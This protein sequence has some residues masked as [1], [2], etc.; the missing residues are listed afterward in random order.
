[1]TVPTTLKMLGQLGINDKYHE[2][3]KPHS[4]KIISRWLEMAVHCNLAMKTLRQITY[5]G[6]ETAQDNSIYLL[7]Q[8]KLYCSTKDV[9][10]VSWDIKSKQS[11]KQE[12]RRRKNK[13][14]SRYHISD[15][16]IYCKFNCLISEGYFR[17]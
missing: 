5:K 17:C 4:K 14:L 1:M 12:L 11:N 8:K 10:T 2:L 15:Q 9:L 3:Q 16:C 6:W 13:F 7:F